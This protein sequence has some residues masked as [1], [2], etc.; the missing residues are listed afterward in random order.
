[1][2]DRRKNVKLNLTE[3]RCRDHLRFAARVFP[4]EATDCVVD[5]TKRH[6]MME[7]V[8]DSQST[9]DFRMN[10]PTASREWN[11]RVL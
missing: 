2:E 8:N 10:A 1:M 5:P 9:L 6:G 11:L 4:P 7:I 3:L